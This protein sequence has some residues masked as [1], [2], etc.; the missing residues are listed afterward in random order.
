MKR[1]LITSATLLVLATLFSIWRENCGNGCS[2]D[3]VVLGLPVFLRTP[4]SPNTGE[5]PEFFLVALLIN[6]GWSAVG[7]AVF[8]GVVDTFERWQDRKAPPG[9]LK[10]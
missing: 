10:L 4:Y 3:R 7:S 6:L 2:F 9:T 8:W 1:Y 5:R